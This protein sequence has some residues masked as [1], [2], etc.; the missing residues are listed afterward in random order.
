M[1]MKVD[2]PFMLKRAFLYL[3]LLVGAPLAVM[4]G[5]AL[6]DGAGAATSAATNAAIEEALRVDAPAAEGPAAS[7]GQAEE[8]GK[9]AR[10]GDGAVHRVEGVEVRGV[11]VQPGEIVINQATIEMTP[12]ATNTVNDLLRGQSSVQFDSSSRSGM[13]GGEITPPK[14]SIRGAKHNE[15]NFMING[16]SNNSRINPGGYD[17]INNGGEPKGDS[18]A[19]IIDP[20]ILKEVNVFTENVPAKYG[21]FLGGVVDARLRDAATDAWHGMA[22]FR[23]TTSDWTNF[24]YTEADQEKADRPAR[25]GEGYQPEFYKYNSSFRLEGPL[26]ENGPGLMLT[27]TNITSIIPLTIVP[28]D[29]SVTER[30]V[31][32]NFMAKINTPPSS[33]LYLSIAAIYAPYKA[34]LYSRDLFD[35]GKFSVDGGGINLLINSHY[36]TPVGRWGNDISYSRSDLSRN[37][38]KDRLYSWLGTGASMA[39]KTYNGKLA[40]EG[41]MGNYKQQQT[42]LGWKSD[43]DLKAFGPEL[44]SNQFSMGFELKK[45]MLEAER[46]GYTSYLN[47]ALSPTAVGSREDGIITGEQF[48]KNKTVY[49]G[50]DRYVSIFMPSLY[51]QD[52]VE[53]E[54]VTLRPGVRVSNDS[55][56]SNT[57]VAPRLFANVDILHDGRFNVFGG[58]SRYYGTQAVFKALRAPSS[59]TPY[60]RTAYNQAWKAG[61]PTSPNFSRLGDLKT[62]YTDEY[63]VGASAEVWETLFK[64]TFVKRDYRD[65][66]KSAPVKENTMIAEYTNRGKTDYKGVTLSAERTFDFGDWGRHV[67]ELSATWS[68]TKG[69]FTDWTDATFENNDNIIKFDPD[70]VLYNGTVTPASDLPA[71]NF[72]SPW[73]ITYTQRS[74]FWEDRV[75]LMGQ[76]RWEQGG[77]RIYTDSARSNKT[78][79]PSG[80]NLLAYKTAHQEDTLNV[81][82]KLSVD[83]IKYK[84]H[85]LTF[86]L[87][88][89]NLLDRKNLSNFSTTESSQGSYSLGRQFY[90]GVKYTF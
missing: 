33:P 61:K 65:Q 14:I 44:F 6:A 23:Y 76:V 60:T 68:A 50:R 7:G 24:H 84:D 52:T 10:G 74:Y 8:S 38:D 19:L 56:T 12:A 81:D 9:A 25:A 28:Q 53:I 36:D 54:R 34:T 87:E 35:G 48:A 82:A 1:K 4:P 13:L 73:V 58:Y 21:S 72:N 46:G 55:L 59:S 5:N 43:L 15:N 17:R 49:D 88:A 45:I 67:G 18:Q 11:T 51:L 57:D 62:P 26:W 89:L 27:Y 29:A 69:N 83:A 47:A 86:E 37:N 71:N 32:Q 63:S 30:R 41:G 40:T 64:L 3:V 42:E 20:D 70:Y 85:T 22:A 66:I 31:N 90:V 77:K 80:L 39:G 2:F 16:M 78:P 75:R 79:G